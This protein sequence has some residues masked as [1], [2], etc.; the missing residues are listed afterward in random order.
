MPI[1]PFCQKDYSVHYCTKNEL[2]LPLHLQAQDR[3]SIYRVPYNKDR[4]PTPNGRCGD[5]G[6]EHGKYHHEGCDQE[7]CPIC[8]GQLFSCLCFLE[9]QEEKIIFEEQ[10][11]LEKWMRGFAKNY[12]L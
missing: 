4:H 2:D 9:E 6:V 3:K 8:N 5:C 12:F 10:K 7:I 11:E 1:C